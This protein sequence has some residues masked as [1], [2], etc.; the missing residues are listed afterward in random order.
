MKHQCDE[1]GCSEMLCGC[2]TQALESTYDE[3]L[4][5]VN[6]S[7]DQ[8]LS[9]RNEILIELDNKKKTVRH[10]QNALQQARDQISKLR[11]ENEGLKKSAA[12]N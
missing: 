3:T 12:I 1:H 2:S 10:L 7:R 6:E 8:L 4:R 9:Q 5:L 11:E